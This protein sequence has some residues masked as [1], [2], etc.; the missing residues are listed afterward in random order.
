MFQFKSTAGMQN[1]FSS[2]EIKNFCEQ[3]RKEFASKGNVLNPKRV[4]HEGIKY[5]YEQCGKEFL[6]KQIVFKHKSAVHEGVKYPC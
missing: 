4:V 6:L 2:E 5:P 1:M 3:R